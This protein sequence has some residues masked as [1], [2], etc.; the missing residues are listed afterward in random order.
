MG[1]PAIGGRGILFCKGTAACP[2]GF[3]WQRNYYEHIIRNEADYARVAAYILDNPRRWE[4][5]SLNKLKIE[6]E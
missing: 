5:D 3:E 2:N 1:Y 6:N 4:Q